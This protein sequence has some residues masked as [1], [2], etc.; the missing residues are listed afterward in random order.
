MIS[1]KS[2]LY[3]FVKTILLG[4]SYT[5]IDGSAIEFDGIRDSDNKPKIKH[6]EPWNSELT[7]FINKDNF[8]VPAVFFEFPTVDPEVESTQ[9]RTN[10]T[11]YRPNKKDVA[12]F[13]LHLI[14]TRGLTPGNVEKDYLALLDLASEIVDALVD[15]S[16]AGIDNI[17]KTNETEDN[18]NEVLKDWI[19]S[20]ESVILE[21]GTTDL[22]DAN[23][24]ENNVNAPVD[25]EVIVNINPIPI[26]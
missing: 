12:T 25:H 3:T 2:Y 10:E 11:N 7:N 14:N 20:F 23:D 5:G 13:A 4:G 18:D 15:R 22:I 21:C 6:F 26:E 9:I 1:T 19:I 8:P 17:R 24:P 16:A